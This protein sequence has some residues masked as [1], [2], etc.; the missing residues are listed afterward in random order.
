MDRFKNKETIS[1]KYKGTVMKTISIDPKDRLELLKYVNI[2]RE[3]NCNTSEKIPI[4]YEHVCELESLMY[5]L[6][7]ILEFQQPSGW[8]ADYQLKEDLPEEI[9]NDKTH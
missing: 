6:S 7:N 1:K 9:S 3:F 4:S 8:Y 2:L 5:R